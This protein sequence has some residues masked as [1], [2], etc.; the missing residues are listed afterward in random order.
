MRAMPKSS[1]GHLKAKSLR[2]DAKTVNFA[3]NYDAGSE[4]VAA[5]MLADVAVVQKFM[6]AKE[7][8]FP[9][10]TPWKDSVRATVEK[11]GFATT[12]LGARRHLRDSLM[13]D[14]RYDAQRAGRQGPNFE[15]QSSGAEMAKLAMGRAWASGVFTGQL[16]T[17]F[18]APVHDELVWSAHRK[19]ALESIK[20]VHAAMTAG[21]ADMKIPIVA[22]VSLGRNY[23]E[24]IECG[25]FVDAPAINAALAEIF[26]R[27]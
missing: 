15:I 12:M 3:T 25:D 23:G 13:S 22:S 11:C 10:I 20:L 7:V 8:A 16:D 14:N 5:T 9:R 1:P 17:R 21:Y 26:D 2:E 27:A 4:T 18:Y 6:D 24:Q 19:D